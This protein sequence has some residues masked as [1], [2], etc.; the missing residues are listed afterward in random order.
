MVLHR[1]I[2]RVTENFEKLV[3]NPVPEPSSAMHA[4]MRVRTTS[5]DGEGGQGDIVGWYARLLD[6]VRVRYRRLRNF[7]KY[8]FLFERFKEGA[9]T[10]DKIGL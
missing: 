3:N 8:T 1:L 5:T 9:L 6:N 10:L 2:V 4:V 7:T